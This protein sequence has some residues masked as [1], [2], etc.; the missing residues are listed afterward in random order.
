MSFSIDHVILSEV[1]ASHREASEQ[2]K[3]PYK[4][5]ITVTAAASFRPK[6][7]T[8][9]AAFQSLGVLRLREF[10]RFANRI[11]CAQ[12]DKLTRYARDR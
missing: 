1:D 11:L 6:N 4:P 5:Y 7:P 10:G 9:L 12:D 3:D 8:N 2:L